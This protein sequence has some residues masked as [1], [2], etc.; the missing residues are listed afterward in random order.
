LQQDRE[1]G[2]FSSIISSNSW[3]R[4]CNTQQLLPN[5][6]YVQWQG[7][8][9]MSATTLFDSFAMYKGTVGAEYSP[10]SRDLLNNTV[11]YGNLNV[12]G[13]LGVGTNTPAEKL[14][15]NGNIRLNNTL[16]VAPG[17][18]LIINATSGS[19]NVVIII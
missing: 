9:Y 18:D 5:T 8:N 6:Y 3:T 16:N 15:V 17:K 12:V 19:G 11:A 2:I 7:Y 14:E 13:N 1:A 10:S 4:Y